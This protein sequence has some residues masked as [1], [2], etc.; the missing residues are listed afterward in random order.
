MKDPRL[1][2][3]SPIPSENTKRHITSPD[4]N[5]QN[6]A[7]LSPKGPKKGK[8]LSVVN[9]IVNNLAG[10]K[11]KSNNK[12]SSI[13]QS[14]NNALSM[15]QSVKNWDG[16][17]Q[18]SK[19]KAVSSSKEKDSPLVA[20][21]PSLPKQ[22]KEKVA[23]KPSTEVKAPLESGPMPPPPF[24]TDFSGLS[25]KDMQIAAQAAAIATAMHQMQSVVKGPIAPEHSA[26]LA[27]Q[28]IKMLQSSSQETSTS[29]VVTVSNETKQS[30]TQITNST[31]T[32]STTTPSSSVKVEKSTKNKNEQPKSDTKSHNNPKSESTTAK[33]VTKPTSLIAKVEGKAENKTRSIDA[34]KNMLKGKKIG[35]KNK[36]RKGQNTKHEP[37]AK[38]SK[39]SSELTERPRKARARSPSRYY[40]QLEQK[41]GTEKQVEENKKEMNLQRERKFSESD[42]NLDEK[43][44]EQKKVYQS[45]VSHIE[46]LEK[47]FKQPNSKISVKT[48]ESV[49]KQFEGKYKKRMMTNEQYNSLSERLDKFASTITGT[50]TKVGNKRIIHHENNHENKNEPHMRDTRPPPFRNDIRPMI[51]PDGRPIG[52][53]GPFPPHG[54]MPRGRGTRFMRPPPQHWRGPPPGHFQERF[55]PRFRN[56]PPPPHMMDGPPMPMRPP[57]PP[58]EHDGMIPPH[59]MGMHHPPNGMEMQQKQPYPEMQPQ[60]FQDMPPQQPFSDMPPQQFADMANHGQ[61]IPPPHWDGPP[62]DFPPWRDGPQSHMMMQ[63][64]GQQPMQHMDGPPGPGLMPMG[65]MIPPHRNSPIPGFSENSQPL[66][67]T[68]T[69]GLHDKYIFFYY[70]NKITLR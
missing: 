1:R 35:D 65:Q 42:E 24:S 59:Q 31:S 50:D 18:S 68:E 11:P 32:V 37:P 23:G 67:E 10:K 48:L 22:K 63:P 46:V 61:P 58:M 39:E 21:E 9:K 53:D 54:F 29:T 15:D 16:T 57:F 38:K 8:A 60:Q 56:G 14:S 6:N 44:R 20:K 33:V 70:S 62:M 45:Y 55:P 3:T 19:R 64:D 26:Q 36:D 28:F 34:P 43:A 30:S 2:T 41:L 40:C 12:N 5:T 25:T 27:A 66:P 69:P 51:G 47:Q 13:K 4:P 52:P 7:K 17:V 49:F